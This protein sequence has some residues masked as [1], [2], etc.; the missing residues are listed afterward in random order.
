MTGTLLKHM[1][2]VLAMIMRLRQ[3]TCHPWLLRRNPGDPS[4]PDDF[5]VSEEDLNASMNIP[6]VNA[7]ADFIRAVDLMG[8]EWVAD[9]SARLKTRHDDAANAPAEAEDAAKWNE[10][11]ICLDVFDGETITQ[12]KHS[13]CQI[14]ISEIFNTAPGDGGDLT[15]EESARGARKCPLC[16]G[17]IEKNKVF[18]AVAFFDAEKEDEEEGAAGSSSAPG[19]DRK[20]KRKMVS[21]LPLPSE[22]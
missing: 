12:C 19:S 10:C 14:C 8:E 16:R 20:G 9:V 11:G 13:Y 15:D 3:L 4:H 7:G 1:S 22:R 17:I 6:V 21:R 2:C 18:A 5:E